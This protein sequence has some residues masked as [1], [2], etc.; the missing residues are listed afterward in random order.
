VREGSTTRTFTVTLETIDGGGGGS[1]GAGSAPEPVTPTA[2]TGVAGGNGGGPVAG[3]AAPGSAAP[4]GATGGT[5]IYSNFA[6]TVELVD[7]LINVGDRVTEGSVIAQVEAMKAKHDIRTPV[8]GTV[9]AIH[10]T[11]GREISS[12]TAIATIG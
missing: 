1:A 10:V 3:G 6:G 5:K 7:V 12:T 8:A 4:A 11:P 2:I 9:T